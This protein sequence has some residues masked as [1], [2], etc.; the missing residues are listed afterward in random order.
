MSLRQLGISFVL[1]ASLGA[2]FKSTVASAGKSVKQLGATIRGLESDPTYK[3]MRGFYKLRDTVR[4]A[5]KELS[6]AESSLE[7]LKARAKESGD[8][9][10]VL[11][12]RIQQSEER[13]QRLR[14]ALTRASGKFMDYKARIDDT[15]LGLAKLKGEYARLGSEMDRLSKKQQRLQRLGKLGSSLKSGL[16]KVNP[17]AI[18]GAFAVP[19]KAAI[20]FET[21]MAGVKKVVDFD[22]PDGL[23]KMGQSILEMSTRIPMASTGLADIVAA[24]GQSGI[25]KKELLKFAESAAIMGV[26]F[27]LTGAESGKM[28][29]DWRAGM[30]LTQARVL[31]LGDAVNYLS[32][33]MNAEASALGEVMQRMGSTGMAAGLTETQT[34]ALGAALLSSGKGPE[35]AS[36]ALK[37]LTGALT[38]GAAATA[39]QQKAFS[40]L[41][42]SADD[43]AAKMQQ[44]APAAIR[45]VFEALSQAPKEEQNALATMLFGKESIGAIM[46]LLANMDNL[47]NAFRLV[48]DESKYSGSMFKE[49]QEQ[50]ATTAKQLQ[51][52]QNTAT[53]LSVTLGDS[54]L[55]AINDLAKGVSPFINSLAKWSKEN[56]RVIKSVA[57][58]GVALLGLKAGMFVLSPLSKLLGGGWSLMKK[59]RGGKGGSGPGGAVPVEVVNGGG[60]E[61]GL[62]GGGSRGGGKRR[63]GSGSGWSNSRLGR[64]FGSGKGFF[65]RVFGAGK[66]LLGAGKGILGLG[67]GL[68][69]KVFRPLGVLTGVAGLAS[70]AAS[71]DFSSMG[72]SL[73]SLGGSAA[74]TAIGATLGSLVPGIGTVIGGM[75]GG[76]L[77]GWLGEKGG[78]VVG[79]AFQ[80]SSPSASPV[81]Q[82]VAAAQQTAATGEGVQITVNQNITVN[83]GDAAAVTSAVNQANDGLEARIRRVIADMFRDR[84]RVA[85]G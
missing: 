26:A 66:G 45:E 38:M 37:N 48:G 67:K 71:G 4:G 50:S 59:L 22:T 69:G 36:T 20:D 47:R 28:M 32:N 74:G 13:V 30:N 40:S 44:D 79:S 81:S 80:K 5:R 35:I 57:A 16:D 72:S 15:G 43:M 2:R 6:T 62:G 51:L 21:S 8:A 18:G 46:P 76:A 9:Q 55:P 54:L 64:A 3:L 52:L 42:L 11:A 60:L 84:E 85:Y 83:G 31:K 65:G 12:S 39:S 33:N 53:R 75:L 78:Q 23:D 68:L 61:G 63:S 24:A 41:G 77:G 25:A 82:A 34:A 49:Y 14:S 10:G 17:L 1:G 73:G 19:I 7:R 70:G 56:P 58:L 27:D 29:A